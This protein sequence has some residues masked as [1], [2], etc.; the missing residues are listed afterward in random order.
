MTNKYKINIDLYSDATRARD[1]LETARD[2]VEKLSRAVRTEGYT[3]YKITVEKVA[4]IVRSNEST[5]SFWVTVGD[6]YDE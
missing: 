1:G 3:S 4:G 6:L 5:Y 2:V